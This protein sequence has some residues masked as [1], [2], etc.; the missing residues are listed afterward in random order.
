MNIKDHLEKANT[1]AVIGFS[2]DKLK[3]AHTVPK[4]LTKF[5]DVIPVNPNHNEISGLE[6]F[7]DLESLD[8]ALTESGKSVDIINVF[9][10]IQDCFKIVQDIVKMKNRPK[11]IWLQSGIQNKE[12]KQLALE[13]NI[14]FIEDKCIYVVHKDL[15]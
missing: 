10:P 15:F 4:Y 6:T 8:R 12:A 2:N 3:A 14:D 1:I 11:L 7:P 13:N 9:R 5:Y